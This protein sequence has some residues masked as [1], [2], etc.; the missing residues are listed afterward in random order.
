M[1]RVLLLLAVVAQALDGN[2][3]CPDS[4][5]PPQPII[6]A[7]WPRLQE[8]ILAWPTKRIG[9]AMD[10]FNVVDHDGK[11]KCDRW[12]Y[13]N[14][15]SWQADVSQDKNT[16]QW[17]G[18]N[19]N[20]RG[21]WDQ[22]KLGRADMWADWC[23]ANNVSILGHAFVWGA[24]CPLWFNSSLSKQDGM[25][26]LREVMTFMM[27]RWAGVWAW[28][29]VMEPFGDPHWK[30]PLLKNNSFVQVLGEDYMD[31]VFRIAKEVDSA[32]K[33]C[34]LDYKL[35]YGMY[36]GMEGT[37]WDSS[38]A[39][40]TF[41]YVSGMHS[42]GVPL[43]CISMEG[44]IAPRGE[45]GPEHRTWLTYN[46]QRYAALD[47]EVHLNAV[48]VAIDQFPDDWDMPRRLSAQ[49]GWYRIMLGACLDA[50]ACT[51]F[52]PYGLTDRYDM[53]ANISSLVFDENFQPKP[54]FWAM[55]D[56]LQSAAQKVKTMLV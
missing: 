42:R 2:D 14:L 46:M 28:N 36:P 41:E 37:T 29:V 20:A 31:I 1:V 48:T 16:L 56:E 24:H 21:E 39:N 6:N 40:V 45:A 27:G 53:G 8:L 47:M 19:Y 3:P 43:D 23:N 33:R 15:T 11:G 5:M 30:Q 35:T 52:E 9:L 10:F 34:L 12:A 38:K 13:G 17:V 54:A 44:H 26:A 22:N 50:D 51:L 32:P 18:L 55:V 7:S 4:Q 49:A 25:D